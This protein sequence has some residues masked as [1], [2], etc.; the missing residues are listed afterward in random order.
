MVHAVEFDE[1]DSETVTSKDDDLLGLDAKIP[2]GK[3]DSDLSESVQNGT[4]LNVV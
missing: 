2:G 3:F 1:E 4:K